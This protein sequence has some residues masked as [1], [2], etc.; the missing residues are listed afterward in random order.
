MFDEDLSNVDEIMEEY[1]SE[2]EISRSRWIFKDGRF[3][4]QEVPEEP[5]G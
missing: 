4:P 3:I 1:E 5:V 2:E